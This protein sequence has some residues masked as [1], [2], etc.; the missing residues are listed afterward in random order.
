MTLNAFRVVDCSGVEAMVTRGQ[1]AAVGHGLFS[2]EDFAA[3]LNGLT[4]WLWPD[5][6]TIPETPCDD[7][8]GC[9]LFGEA[10][11][12]LVDHGASF[13]H[14]LMH[15]LDEE[16]GVSDEANQQHEGWG[17]RGAAPDAGSHLCQPWASPP[18][19][20]GSWEDVAFGVHVAQAFAGVTEGL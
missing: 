4:I 13:T 5:D 18:C 10:Q 1:T 6:A 17:Q 8:T 12:Y 11:V 7:A 3:S 2:D 19:L 14:E 20:D 16:R 15:R 9:L